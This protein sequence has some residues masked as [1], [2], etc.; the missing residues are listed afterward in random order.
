MLYPI[1]FLQ[2]PNPKQPMCVHR[3]PSRRHCKLH[4]VNHLIL[5]Y[6]VRHPDCLLRRHFHVRHLVQVYNQFLPPE[7]E[8]WILM[9]PRETH[10]TRFPTRRHYKF[11]QNPTFVNQFLPPKSERW[12]L[13]KLN[14][15]RRNEKEENV[16]LTQLRMPSLMQ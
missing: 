7:N 12:I 16:A 5:L 13:M 14:R 2:V 6:N 10:D 3:F 8:R 11:H 15:P 4:Q 1:I 9:T